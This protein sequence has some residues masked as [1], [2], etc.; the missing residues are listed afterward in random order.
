VFRRAAARWI[1]RYGVAEIIGVCTAVASAW[2]VD[3]LGAGTVATAY[4]G[5][6]GENVGYYGFIAT[7]EMVASYHATRLTGDRYR[8]SHVG[9]VARDLTIE[10]GPAEALDSLILRPLMM[11]LGTR[12][13]GGGLGIVAGKLAADLM[14]YLPVIATYEARRTRRAEPPR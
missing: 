5:A 10:F 13:I 6:F 14:F 9:I 11:G 4:A 2:L 1:A 7:R 12:W 8:A 3:M